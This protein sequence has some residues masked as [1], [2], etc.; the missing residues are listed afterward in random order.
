MTRVPLA[1]L[2]EAGDDIAG[3]ESPWAIGGVGVGLTLGRRR[4]RLSRGEIMASMDL[5][6]AFLP[7]D[8]RTERFFES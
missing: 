3:P 5:G 7:R 1:K 8:T 6:A 2:E 4:V